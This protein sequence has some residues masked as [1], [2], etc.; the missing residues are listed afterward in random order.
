M[1]NIVCKIFLLHC[2]I[3]L[4][5]QNNSVNGQTRG[6]VY[7][8][9]AFAGNRITVWYKVGRAVNPDIRLEIKTGLCGIVILPVIN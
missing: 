3:I 6:F 9:S 5:L 1:M 8:L 4:V 7:V 2:A